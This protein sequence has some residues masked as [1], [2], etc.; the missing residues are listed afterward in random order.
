[1]ANATAEIPLGGIG[2]DGRRFHVPVKTSQTI[3]SGTMVAQQ[4]ADGLLVPA[5]AAGA[6][7][8]IGKA[9]HTVTS[10]SAGQ[11]LVVETDRIYTF[12]NGTSTDA[13]SEA[14]LMGS[15][16]YAFD[17]HTVLRQQQRRHASAVR[18]VRGHGGGRQG[19]RQDVDG[20]RRVG[21][22]WWIG[23]DGSVRNGDFLLGRAR[24]HRRDPHRDVGH[25]LLSQDGG[26]YGR[27]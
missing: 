4:I 20:V 27:R 25:R 3:Y 14:S 19:P 2:Q 15:P 1:M 6:G 24:C 5:T 16:A 11:R 7:P 12:A 8:A 26:G 13:F 22:G 10:A 18:D 23:A 17:D 9:T 21:A